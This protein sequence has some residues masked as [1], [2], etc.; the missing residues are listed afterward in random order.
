MSFNNTKTPSKPTD[1]AKWQVPM[2][3]SSHGARE[4][5]LDGEV[6]DKFIKLFPIR[7]MMLWFGISFTT[8]QRFKRELGLEKDMRRIRKELARD[9]KKTC[10]RNGYYA[11]LR[12]KPLSQA[13]QEAAKKMR[14]TTPPP[15]VKLRTDNPRRYRQVLQKRAKA[16]KDLWKKE[17]IRA[18]YGLERKTR[19]YIPDNP[20]TPHA[21]AQ[22]SSMIRRNNYFPDPEHKWW[23]CYDKQTRRSARREATAVRYGL[24]I[25][26]GEND[27]ENE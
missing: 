6:K 14:E 5:Y 17:K 24:T 26:E 9:V 18:E 25:I 12:G 23:V 27:E 4:Y 2:R 8:L 13:C 11:S 15:L 16:R 19:L 1:A 7:R 3:V 20:L 22:K 21:I 10:E